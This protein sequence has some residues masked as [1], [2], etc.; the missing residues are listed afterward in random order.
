[1]K[2]DEKKDP[3]FF[4]WQ[5]F[6]VTALHYRNFQWQQI[7]LYWQALKWQAVLHIKNCYLMVISHKEQAPLMP[8]HYLKPMITKLKGL[9]IKYL[10]NSR[11][12]ELSW[13][14]TLQFY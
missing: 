8:G 4:K 13:M 6:L 10:L 1:M 7:I 12:K 9:N 14:V 2:E 5:T 3:S 11:D